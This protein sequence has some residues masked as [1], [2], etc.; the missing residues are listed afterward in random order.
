M[1][2]RSLISFTDAEIEYRSIRA[3]NEY[4]AHVE[5]F[6]NGAVE[7]Y[8]H[9]PGGDVCLEPFEYEPLED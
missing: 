6:R 4:E 5:T 7:L 8:V 2:V 3:G 1:R 9:T